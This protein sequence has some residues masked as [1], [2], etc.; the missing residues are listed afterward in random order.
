VKA[1]IDGEGLQRYPAY[2]DLQHK[3]A[4][5]AGVD[6]EECMF[7]NGSDQGIDL[8]VRCCCEAGTE[9]VIPTPTFAMYEQAALSEGLVIRSP[10]FDREL[11]L[12]AKVVLDA[13]GPKTSLIVLSNPNNPTGT[14]IERETILEV[15]RKAP[16]CAILVDECYY[17]FMPPESTVINE[18]KKYPNLFVC[19]TFSKT[20]GMP[21]LRLGYLVSTATN[22]SQICCVRGPYDVNTLACVA[23]K[24]ALKDPAYVYEFVKE[25]N[26]VAKPK[27]ESFLREKG[28]TFWPSTANFIFCYFKKPEE[29]EVALRE[30]GILVRPKKDG[31]GTVGL[32][33]T[34]GT[35]SQI[36]KLI[37]H[38]TKLLGEEPPAKRP[39]L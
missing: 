25:V 34:I 27:F 26:E 23:F 33:V 9:V 19:R 16:K 31:N 8:V 2:G 1:H 11:G 15:V 18:V 7:T 32:R 10:S 39:K 28:I 13:V 3:I 22:I 20:W 30:Q 38:L 6:P 5:Y 21:S 4:K 35:E 14:I 29:L 36:D 12:P 24:A 17:E 37:E